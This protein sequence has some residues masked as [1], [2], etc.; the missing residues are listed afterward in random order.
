MAAERGSS[1]TDPTPRP[2]TS[3]RLSVLPKLRHRPSWFRNPA[4][5]SPTSLCGCRITFTPPAI[6]IW[7]SPRLRLSQARWIDINA[8]EHIVSTA[9][10]GP[11]QSK[12]YETR[13][14]IDA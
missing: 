4:C 11:L 10:L 9:T 12:M 14:A 2:A 6:A 5:D 13:F 1:N 8:D 3:P 7:L